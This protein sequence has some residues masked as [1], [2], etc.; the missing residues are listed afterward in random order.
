LTEMHKLAGREKTQEYIIAETSKIY[1][2]QG[3]TISRKHMEVIIRQMF[4]RRKIR[5][6]GETHLS[7]GDVVEEWQ[8]FEANDRAV[9]EGKT[10]AYA[11]VQILGIMEVSL[12]RRSWLSAASFQNTTRVLI[13][14]AVRG[15]KDPLRGLKE[16]V[17]LGRL[18]P[19]GSGYK[20]SKK[21]DEIRELSGELEKM[22]QEREGSRRGDDENAKGIV[23][24]SI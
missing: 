18:I 16:N 7:V 22:H 20:G 6:A 15:T 19:A 9:E 13:G 14:N 21:Y 11:E 23:M 1:E 8:L 4:S 5:D 17:I 12:T 24:N 2:L 3:V 10:P